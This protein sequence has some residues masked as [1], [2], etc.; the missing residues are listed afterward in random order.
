MKG[1]P[2]SFSGSSRILGCGRSSQRL[3][4]PGTERGREPGPAEVARTP[5]DPENARFSECS[6]HS[7][8]ETVLSALLPQHLRGP[9]PLWSVHSPEAS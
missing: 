2:P 3:V 1:N 8:E 4:L 9:G 5:V 6:D 7:R